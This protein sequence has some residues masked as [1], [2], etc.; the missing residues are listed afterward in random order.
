[1]IAFTMLRE[2]I[3]P[4]SRL[5]PPD[6]APGRGQHQSK[7]QIKRF[8]CSFLIKLWRLRTN[9][10]QGAG[11][12]I[13]IVG[14]ALGNF[15]SDGF[16][17]SEILFPRSLARPTHSAAAIEIS[18]LAD[19][20]S[21]RLPSS[22]NQLFRI[23]IHEVPFIRDCTHRRG[24]CKDFRGSD[25][26]PAMHADWHQFQP[27]RT[28]SGGCSIKIGLPGG[29]LNCPFGKDNLLVCRTT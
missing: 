4:Y 12:K 3:T 16:H 28:S 10:R 27:E 25:P 6:Q 5:T 1:M 13:R 18:C 8:S 14:F 19:H 23:G 9:W 7:T 21:V 24:C 26:V 17:F 2:F 20:L 22:P 29:P 15:P 11:R